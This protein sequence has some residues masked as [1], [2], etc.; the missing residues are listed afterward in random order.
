MVRARP[1]RQP[2]PREDRREDDDEQRLDRLEPARRIGE[3]ED[4][5]P[6]G[7]IG[8]EREARS[9]LFES[10][11]EDQREQRE[12]QRRDD[13]S[14]L[15]LRERFLRQLRRLIR[16]RPSA[17]SSLPRPAMRYLRP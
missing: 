2:D 13:A 7:A 14:P 15:L 8:E 9:R 3:A 12:D 1:H 4:R 17:A 6:R 10:G 5:Q 11:P 16:P